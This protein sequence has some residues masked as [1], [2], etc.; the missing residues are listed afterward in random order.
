MLGLLVHGHWEMAIGIDTSPV[1]L[2]LPGLSLPVCDRGRCM[3]GE[4]WGLGMEMWQPRHC[5]AKNHKFF[6]G[7]KS[8][9]GWLGIVLMRACANKNKIS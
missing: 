9:V 5:V 1:N 8:A 7:Q 2:I 6:G 4:R 3:E